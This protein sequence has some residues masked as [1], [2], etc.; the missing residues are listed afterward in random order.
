MMMFK[1]IITVVTL[2]STIACSNNDK[3]SN[4]TKQKETEINT[5]DVLF[6][7]GSCSNQAFEETMWD[8]VN[9]Y[10]PEVWIWGGDAVY[11]DTEDPAYMK[12]Q[13]RN[14]KSKPGYHT[15]LKQT[16]VIGTWDDHD[17]GANDAGTEYPMKYESKKM[18]LDFLDVAEDDVRRKRDGVYASY[19]YDYDKGSIKVILLDARFFRT[20]LTPDPTGKKRYI[21]NGDS[22]GTILGENQWQW[23]ENELNNSKADFNILVTGI[24]VLSNLHGFEAWGNMPHERD[25]LLNL[26]SSS[27]AKGAFILSGDRHVCE[28]SKIKL[29]NMDYPIYDITSSGLTHSYTNVGE[30]E[31]P[32]RVSDLV[33]KKNFALLYF[34]FNTH[35]LKV[36]I[37]GKENVALMNETIK[38]N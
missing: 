8:E 30:E 3:V 34:D 22:D 29:D 18:F 4:E 16:K 32:Y 1:K 7:F 10:K 21:D 14:Q 6:A 5:E 38:Y 36:D 13:Y 11:S 15:L 37:R 17:F 28:I 2:I 9:S 19:N 33:G 23:L 35:T 25:R 24:Q 12:K 20:P 26:I 31:N 27:K